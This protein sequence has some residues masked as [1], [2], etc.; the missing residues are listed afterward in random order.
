MVGISGDRPEKQLAF[1]EKFSLTFPLVSDTSG[2]LIDSYG[3]GQVLGIIAKR[4][5]FLVSPEGRIAWVWP[6][7]RV[8]GHADEVVARIRELSNES[9]ERP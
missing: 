6:K 3:A 2:D 5:T 1:I 7:V 8:E 4:S 9:E